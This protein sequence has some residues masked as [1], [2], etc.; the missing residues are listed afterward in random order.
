MEKHQ[1]G[2]WSVYYMKVAFNKIAVIGLGYIGLPT[3]AILA[4][5]ELD[6]IGVDIDENTVNIVNNGKVHIVEPDLDTLVH[7]VV[8]AGKLRAV[9]VPEAADV[10]LI[11]VPTPITQAQQPDISYVNAA[12]RSISHL[13]Q[14]GNLIILE[15]TSPV[16]TTD[17]ISKMLAE[18]RSDLI[19]PH[20]DAE[21]PDVH[22]AYCAERVMP[23]QIIRELVENDR[24]IG[25]I[26]PRCTQVA[27]ELYELFVRGK[28][29]STNSRTA[30][31]TKLTENSFRDVNIAFANELS[32]ICEKM[33]INVWELINLANH[34][35]R[36]KIL[37]PG[38]GV[39]G[40]CIAV[41]PWFI[42][43]SAPE[44]AKIIRAAREVNDDKPLF[45]LKKIQQA[46]SAFAKPK[47]ACL[48]ITYKPNTDDLRESPVIKILQALAVDK[49]L[50]I[51]IV[52][53]NITALPDNLRR[54]PQCALVECDT[55]LANADIVV[56]MVAH[57]EF[58]HLNLD[59]LQGKVVIDTINLQGNQAEKAAITFREPP[60]LRSVSELVS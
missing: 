27:R 4:S 1:N 34:H 45:V 50:S 5:R 46:A 28:C 49:N 22:I 54:Y 12:V 56:M 39:G 25:G 17:S 20:Q 55:A 7:N 10:F 16:G 26:T 24:I 43:H 19:F 14:K 36:V 2:L 15:S 38:P 30:E 58:K 59:L 29:I 11:T 33:Q 48:G 35:P 9:T 18:T 51:D 21:Q 60:A 13:I 42:V 31:M 41:D 37:Q 40:H 47:I 32:V 8:I 3:A 6:V 52:E 44:E 23:G 57:H 53:P